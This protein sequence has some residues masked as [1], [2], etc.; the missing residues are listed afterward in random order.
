MAWFSSAYQLP[1]LLC[2]RKEKI[3]EVLY[4]TMQIRVRHMIVK[5]MEDRYSKWD[6]D[7][8]PDDLDNMIV[9][10]L[11]DQLNDKFWDVLPLTKCQKRKTQVSAPS[12]PERVDTSPSTKRRKEKDTAP[13]MVFIT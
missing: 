13:E 6:E 8:P 2:T 11:N 1:K 5:A 7:K 10:I 4:F 12:V 9:D 3:S